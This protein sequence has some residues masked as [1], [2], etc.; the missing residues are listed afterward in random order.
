MVSVKVMIGLK[1]RCMSGLTQGMVSVKVLIGVNNAV[2]MYGLVLVMLPEC[3]TCI[4]VNNTV[5]M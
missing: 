4:G 1:T 2:R 3:T 5:R